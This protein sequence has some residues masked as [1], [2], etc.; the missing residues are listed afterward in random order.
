MPDLVIEAQI[1]D[2]TAF[3]GQRKFTKLDAGHNIAQLKSHWIT[4]LVAG[5]WEQIGIDTVRS[6][7]SPWYNVENVPN[8]YLGNR[9]VVIFDDTV[10]GQ[11]RVRV[12]A[13]YAGTTEHLM[14]TQFFRTDIADVTAFDRYTLASPYQLVTWTSRDPNTA[15]NV[16]RLGDMVISAI[17]IPKAVFQRQQ[18]VHCIYGTNRLRGFTQGLGVALGTGTDYICYRT[19]NDTGSFTQL[20]KQGRFITPTGGRS[21]RVVAGRRVWN[22]ALDPTMIDSTKWSAFFTP[23]YIAYPLPTTTTLTINGFLWDSFIITE[24]FSYQAVIEKIGR[25]WHRYAGTQDLLFLPDGTLF[26]CT[27]EIGIE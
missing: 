8:W 5:G 25:Q 19:R 3:S 9:A 16:D 7:Q 1:P 4:T 26:F 17:N 10:G 20:G 27:T 14:T 23:T 22:R 12:G 24:G 21:P 11:L 15:A 6:Q 2:I 18:V 13:D